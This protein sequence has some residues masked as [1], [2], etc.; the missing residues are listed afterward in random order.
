MGRVAA[1]FG[2]LSKKLKIFQKDKDFLKSWRIFRNFL[3]SCTK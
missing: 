2:E 3:E 1:F